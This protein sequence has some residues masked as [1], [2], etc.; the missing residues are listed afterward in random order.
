MNQHKIFRC[1][2]LIILLSDNYYSIPYLSQL[3]EISQRSVYRYLNLLEAIG[4]ELTTLDNKY[5]IK[6]G[7]VPQQLNSLLK[8]GN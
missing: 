5:S 3:L 8:N 4:F 7:I 2:K 6:P 1:L